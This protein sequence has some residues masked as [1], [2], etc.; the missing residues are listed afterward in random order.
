[1][2]LMAVDQNALC[3]S[4]LSM[5]AILNHPLAIRQDLLLL[6][7]SMLTFKLEILASK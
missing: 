3:D 6:I 2:G 1:M 4:A 5:L 7:S